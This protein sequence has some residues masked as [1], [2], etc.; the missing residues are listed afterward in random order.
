MYIVY[1]RWWHDV[2]LDVFSGQVLWFKA[3][4]GNNDFYVA[5][6][7]LDAAQQHLQLLVAKKSLRG[8]RDLRGDI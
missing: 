1:L 2:L 4:I 7:L 3:V 5:I 6:K 8:D